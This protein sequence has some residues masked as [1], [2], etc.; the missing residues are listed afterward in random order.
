MKS[1]TLLQINPKKHGYYSYME[2]QINTW[3]GYTNYSLTM[4]FVVKLWLHKG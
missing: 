1:E 4:V 2:P 3:F